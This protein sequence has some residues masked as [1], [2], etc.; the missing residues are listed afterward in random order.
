MANGAV[1]LKAADN[2]AKEDTERGN[3]NRDQYSEDA[4]FIGINSIYL[5]KGI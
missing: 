4:I 1:N 5:P 3:R 2:G